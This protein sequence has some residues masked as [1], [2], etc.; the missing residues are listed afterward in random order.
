MWC[1]NC[2]MCSWGKRACLNLY[3]FK[4]STILFAWYLQTPYTANNW[5]CFRNAGSCIQENEKSLNFGWGYERFLCT[6]KFRIL[7]SSAFDM[8]F[9]K[10]ETFPSPV[11]TQ[12]QFSSH[13]VCCRVC[14]AGEPCIFS[15]SGQLWIF[16]IY[17]MDR[18]WISCDSNSYLL[19]LPL[20]SLLFYSPW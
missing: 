6:F 17:I 10:A 1:L 20:F 12:A 19:R 16:H 4:G 8:S 15:H 2:Y 7:W 3:A 13:W 18:P 14:V 11:L 5:K 9:S